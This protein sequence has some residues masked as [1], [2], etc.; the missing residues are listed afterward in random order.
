[1]SF[2]FICTLL[3][4]PERWPGSPAMPD[5]DLNEP[6]LSAPAVSECF[7]GNPLTSLLGLGAW[8]DK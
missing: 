1:M 3:Q 8:S 2:I 6:L 7:T 5:T 4:T